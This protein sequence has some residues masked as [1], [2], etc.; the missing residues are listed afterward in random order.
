[1]RQTPD[2]MQFFTILQDQ[3]HSFNRQADWSTHFLCTKSYRIEYHLIKRFHVRTVQSE[4]SAPM[5]HDITYMDIQF[6]LLTSAKFVRAVSCA[7]K[8]KNENDA[9]RN[10]IS[11]DFDKQH[12]SQPKSQQ[13]N[14][15]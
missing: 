12:I 4:Q 2:R 10:R 15:P 3:L 6:S 11:D 13:T 14:Q 7:S 5:W 9:I 8:V 1:M